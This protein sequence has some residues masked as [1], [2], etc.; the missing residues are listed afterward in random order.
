MEA[1]KKFK[2]LIIV[3][4]IIVVAFIA[5][6]IFTNSSAATDSTALQKTAVDSSTAGSAS[7]SSVP[8]NELAQSFVDQ[9]LTIQNINL[10]LAF[11]S[12]P[13][14]LG[15]VDNHVDID[16]QPIG[17]PNPFAPIGKDAG[18]SSSN[19]QDISGSVINSANGSVPSSIFGSG[20]TASSTTAASSSAPIKTPVKKKTTVNNTTQQ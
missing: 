2:Y 1:L 7:N 8:N 5:Y 11:F 12:D 6:T 20:N 16:P 17:R 9:L 4:V 13:V 10:K 3:V 19:Y 15:L 14:F 18:Q